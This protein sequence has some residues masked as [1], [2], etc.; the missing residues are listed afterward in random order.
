V[1]WIESENLI[2]ILQYVQDHCGFDL[3]LSEILRRMY[4]FETGMYVYI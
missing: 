3:F 1:I 4:N 2:N